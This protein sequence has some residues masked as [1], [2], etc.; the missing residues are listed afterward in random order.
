MDKGRGVGVAAAAVDEIEGLLS[1]FS[2][3]TIIIM[4]MLYLRCYVGYGFFFAMD[5]C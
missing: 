4:F 2:H 3:T 5:G 1:F